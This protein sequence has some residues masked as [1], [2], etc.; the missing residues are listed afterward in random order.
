M[1]VFRCVWASEIKTPWQDRPTV[2]VYAKTVTNH[3]QFWEAIKDGASSTYF[4]MVSPIM[5]GPSDNAASI[6]KSDVQA[7][8]K[9]AQ[10]IKNAKAGLGHIRCP[11][12][13]QPVL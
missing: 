4:L 8:C 2:F 12:N 5:L 3:V 1:R 9:I 10:G 11:D 13:L 6:S 7:A